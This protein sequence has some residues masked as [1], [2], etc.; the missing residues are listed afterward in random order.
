MTKPSSFSLR[1]TAIRFLL[2]RKSVMAKDLVFVERVLVVLKAIL[3]I[4]VINV[5]R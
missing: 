2:F 4:F 1:L 3:E 5:L